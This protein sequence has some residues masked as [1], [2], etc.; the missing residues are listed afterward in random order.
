MTAAEAGRSS[1]SLSDLKELF[2][3]ELRLNTNE[4]HFHSTNSFSFIHPFDYSH[5]SYYGILAHSEGACKKTP[6]LLSY[7]KEKAHGCSIEQI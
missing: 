7:K 5:V 1:Q 3:Q 4:S 2:Y 6:A